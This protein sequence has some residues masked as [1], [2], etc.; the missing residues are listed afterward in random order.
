[1]NYEE[2]RVSGVKELEKIGFKNKRIRIWKT[3]LLD[4]KFDYEYQDDKYIWITNVLA[5]KAV[6]SGN[7]GVG[8]ILVDCSGKIIAKGHNEVFNPYFRSDRHAEMVVMDKFEDMNRNFT[9]LQG[10]TL[11]TSLESCPMCLVRL[12][13][14]G[15]HKILH[16]ALDIEGGM[17]HE[18]KNLPPF[19]SNLGEGKIFSQALCSQEMINAANKIF[20]LNVEELIEK[21]KNFHAFSSE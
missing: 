7:F 8:C 6:D 9:C 12:I 3:M 4:Y 17:V 13:T 11:Y 2:I 14:S 20:H 5:L 16:A 21:A 18:S 19:W 1:M 15:V 10:Y